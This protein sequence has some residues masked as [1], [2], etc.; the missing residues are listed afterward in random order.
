[1]LPLP[2]SQVCCC[3]HVAPIPSS[4]WTQ[5][6]LQL[7]HCQEVQLRAAPSRCQQALMALAGEQSAGQQQHS[8][9][10]FNSK[11]SATYRSHSHRG[12]P[13]CLPATAA[14]T[15]TMLA[16]CCS[17]YNPVPPPLPLACCALR[18]TWDAFY[19]TVSARGLVEGLSSLHAGGIAPRLL[20]IDDGWQVGSVQGTQ[21]VI[22]LLGS[23]VVLCTL[24]GCIVCLYSLEMCSC[25]RH[26]RPGRAWVVEII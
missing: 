10:D 17:V 21:L 5:A 13:P 24:A 9:S 15:T 16:P 22:V 3:W 6:L 7:Q 18:C 19:S 1:M 25:R 12:D 11:H 8:C 2:C 14:F 23:C 26:G 4:L 20:I